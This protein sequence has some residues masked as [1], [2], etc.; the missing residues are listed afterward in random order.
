TGDLPED[1]FERF[2]Q[3]AASADAGGGG[4]LFLPWLNGII[5]PQADGD[6]RGGFL[7][8]SYHTTRPQMARAV[9]EGIA[10]SWRWMVEAVQKFNGRCF[11]SLRLAGGGAQSDVWAQI[12]ADVIGIPMQRLAQPR[13]ANVRGAAFLALN[14]LGMLPIQDA[15]ERVETDRVFEP[16]SEYRA[17]YDERYR[18]FR[19]SY[20]NLKPVF[21]ALNQP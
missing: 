5:A 4:L 17:L 6:A 12:M 21:R 19:A 16:D 20:K 2:H 15:A 11:D 18:Q 1:E 8:L 13:L 14:S 10:C 9:L 7:N 3:A